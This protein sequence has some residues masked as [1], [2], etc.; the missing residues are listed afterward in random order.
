M[1]N[2]ER[3]L[4][5]EQHA[6]QGCGRL[7]TRRR[8]DDIAGHHRLACRRRRM[9]DRLTGVQAHPN[10]ERAVFEP[11]PGC[12]LLD[13]AHDGQA[14]AH[15]ALRVVF[16]GGRN[17]E[18]GHSRVTDELLQRPSMSTDRVTHGLEVRVLDDRHVLR[19]ESFGGGGEAREVARRGR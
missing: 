9:D 2:G 3:G 11:N 7:K 6:I 4:G 15:G 16:A 1:R 5:T 14:A 10:V 12:E 13:R 8:V 17:A 18:H 19:V